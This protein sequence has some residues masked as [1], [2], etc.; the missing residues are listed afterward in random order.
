[1][2][3]FV[4][5]VKCSGGYIYDG[6]P[7]AYKALQFS[8]LFFS[9]CVIIIIFRYKY[10]LTNV[11]FWHEDNLILIHYQTCFL[12]LTL[13]FIVSLL[14]G[15]ALNV[16]YWHTVY[17]FNPLSCFQLKQIC[18]CLGGGRLRIFF[19]LPSSFCVYQ[20]INCQPS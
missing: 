15:V 8:L 10:I 9:C 17:Y 5:F 16:D 19:F 3:R 20:S 12:K 13:Y 1:M 18:C 11:H 2:F 14:V 4:H 6:S 7:L